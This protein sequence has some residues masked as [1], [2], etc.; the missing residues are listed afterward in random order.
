MVWTGWFIFPPPPEI[1]QSF[2]ENITTRLELLAEYDALRDTPPVTQDGVE[3]D[4]LINAGLAIDM[5]GLER[6][7]AS[8][9][10]LFRT[11]FQ[12]MVGETLPR[13]APQAEF[14]GAIL[15]QANEKPVVFR[16]L[17]I[18]GDKQVPFLKSEEEV[19]PAMGWR[20]IRIGLDR[21]AL[22]RYQ[23]RALLQAAAGRDLNVMFPMIVDVAEFV[24]AKNILQK[25]IDRQ[26]AGK[27]PLPKNIRV[28]TMLEVPSLIWQ[29]DH[30]LPLVDF[31]SVGSNDLMQFFFACDRENAKLAGRYDP[32]SP[33]ALNMLAH[34]IEK[35]AAHNTPVT[36]CGELGGQPLAALA[37]MAVGFRRLSIAPAAVGPV[38][39]MIRSVN[40]GDLESYF[41]VLLSRCD[42]SVRTKLL[43]FARDHNIKI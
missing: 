43:T 27:K 36:L 13:V 16:T 29:L 4:L 25:E 9:V 31:I 8:G 37:L 35:C 12:F 5:D 10:G 20:A 40:M 39:M 11:E 33:P 42:H 19:N 26:K 32:L 2:R 22:L 17:D 24:A 18:G 28:G 23:L 14:Y 7:G 6:T 30:L 38:K 41:E 15:D 3:I 34:I 1:L 21:P